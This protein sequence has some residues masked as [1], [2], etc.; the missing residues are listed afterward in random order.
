MSVCNWCGS[1]SDTEAVLVSLPEDMV[2]PGAPTSRGF[3]SIG[4]FR[5]WVEALY[6]WYFTDGQP[7]PTPDIAARQFQ[8]MLE[9]EGGT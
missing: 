6:W 8:E 3:S 5:S 1:V 2:A 9:D 4:C 7:V